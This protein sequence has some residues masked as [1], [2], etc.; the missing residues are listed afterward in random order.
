MSRR[1]PGVVALPLQL[2]E[3]TP[4]IEVWTRSPDTGHAGWANPKAADLERTLFSEAAFCS[5]REC[6]LC[7]SQ[8]SPASQF[9]GLGWVSCSLATVDDGSTFSRGSGRLNQQGGG[10]LKRYDLFLE[11]EQLRSLQALS[12]NKETSVSLLIRQA[13]DDFINRQDSMDIRFCMFSQTK[14]RESQSFFVASELK[15]V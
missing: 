12:K 2:C 1:S 9:P 8:I 11:E 10:S 14:E 5:I 13:L 4:S 7:T 15:L 6:P 3:A